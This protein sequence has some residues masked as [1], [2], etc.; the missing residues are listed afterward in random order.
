MAGDGAP[1]GEH[2]RSRADD[3]GCDLL[4]MCN[5]EGAVGE[6]V[7]SDNLEGNAMGVDGMMGLLLHPKVTSPLFVSTI[8]ACVR[9]GVAS[10]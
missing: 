4:T 1:E 3:E 9:Y 2:C 5:C 8:G 7:V 10:P 6:D